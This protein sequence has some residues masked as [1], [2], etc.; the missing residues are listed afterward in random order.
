MRKPTF[1]ICGNKGA[2]QLHS[3]CAADQC[4]CFC[5][6]D[7]TNPL[8]HKFKISSLQSSS[9]AVQPDLCQTPKAGG[10]QIKINQ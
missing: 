8:L 3:N 1:G 2:D 7:S 9:V 5:Y 4:L 10:A 6:I